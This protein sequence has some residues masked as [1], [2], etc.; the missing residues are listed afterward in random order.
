MAAPPKPPAAGSKRKA[1]KTI[2][3]AEL[4]PTLGRKKL[5]QATRNLQDRKKILG[6]I[7]GF[8][9]RWEKVVFSTQGAAAGK[10]WKPKIDGT[11]A[12]L[13]RTGA[14]KRALTAAPRQMKASVQ[15]R[16]PE[17]SLALAAGR[18]GPHSRRGTGGRSGWKGLGGSMPR[19]NPMPRPPK[20]QMQI[21]TDDL[22][23]ITLPKG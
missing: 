1:S 5:T 22:L 8:A 7:A 9:V 12:R 10:R 23:G 14:I 15:V 4:D 2:I 13:H 16:G 19:R 6:K 3:R 18:Y 17:E 11:P 20:R 21:L